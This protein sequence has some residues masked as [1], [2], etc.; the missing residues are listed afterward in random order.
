M[1]NAQCFI[2][3]I[4]RVRNNKEKIPNKCKNDLKIPDVKLI[5]PQLIV[6]HDNE[7]NKIF[8]DKLQNKMFIDK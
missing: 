7:K 1:P 3:K 4:Q 6:I 2:K 8:F 5:R